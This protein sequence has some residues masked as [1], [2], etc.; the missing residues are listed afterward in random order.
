MQ[1]EERR[2]E[3]RGG[4]GRRGEG[5]ASQSH[6]PISQTLGRLKRKIASSRAY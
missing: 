3:G 4:E 2:G 6:K 1:G 5:K